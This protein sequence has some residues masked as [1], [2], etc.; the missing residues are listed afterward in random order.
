ML[1]REHQAVIELEKVGN[2]VAQAAIG[3][4]L[5]ADRRLAG[6]QLEAALAGGGDAADLAR[7]QDHLDDADAHIAASEFATAILDYKKAWMDA[8]KAL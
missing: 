6:V 8:V 5:E 7:A 2:A 3:N 4:L 1:D